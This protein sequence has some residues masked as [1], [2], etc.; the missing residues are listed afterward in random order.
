MI[1]LS[2]AKAGV[3]K[4]AD[5]IANS[6]KDVEKVRGV[7]NEDVVVDEVGV[8]GDV[9]RFANID[10]AGEVVD[11]IVSARSYEFNL[12]SVD[13]WS[14]MTKATIDMVDDK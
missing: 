7:G 1:G 13:A 4:S 5:N 12:K 2:N 11:M 10:L 8:D 9:D 6:I 3:Q 14:E